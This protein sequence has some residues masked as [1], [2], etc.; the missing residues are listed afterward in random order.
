MKAILQPS[1]LPHLA[2]PAQR[3]L[4]AA[5]IRTLEDLTRFSEAEISRLHG[6]GPTALTILREFLAVHSLSFTRPEK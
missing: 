2:S 3:A 4:A 6:I 5:G 1:G